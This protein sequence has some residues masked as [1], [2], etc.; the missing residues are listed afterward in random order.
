MPVCVCGHVSVS[1]YALCP[2]PLSLYVCV[3]L[4]KVGD[5]LG[6]RCGLGNERRIRRLEPPHDLALQSESRE[7]ARARLTARH[8][9]I[10]TLTR[11]QTRHS[12]Y[13]S[14]LYTHTHTHG[15][16]SARTPWAAP[17]RSL[18]AISAMRSSICRFDTSAYLCTHTHT[19]T[20]T[21]TQRGYAWYKRPVNLP[22]PIS[23][24]CAGARGCL[25]VPLCLSLCERGRGGAYKVRRSLTMAATPRAEPCSSCGP[26][27]QRPP[28]PPS[29]DASTRLPT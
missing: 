11:E 17:R 16:G 6:W 26:A 24:H 4:P 19:H 12:L 3:R 22:E 8:A 29:S 10:Q 14:D 7:G 1:P 20:H 27:P 2:P 25:C 9:H 13:H 5:G 15:C 21:H 23:H 18:T 28:P